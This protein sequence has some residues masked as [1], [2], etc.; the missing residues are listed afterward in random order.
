MLGS[1]KKK[2]RHAEQ[3]VAVSKFLKDQ[4]RIKKEVTL[5]QA[6]DWLHPEFLEAVHADMWK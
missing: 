5:A 2:G 6:R 3:V 4:G 1:S